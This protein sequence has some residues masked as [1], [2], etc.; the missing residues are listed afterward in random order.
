MTSNKTEKCSNNGTFLFLKKV[1][2][3]ASLLI[4]IAGLGSGWGL[5]ANA[6]VNAKEQREALTQDVDLLEQR[7]LAVEQ[8]VVKFEERTFNIKE[9]L[10]RIENKLQ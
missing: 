6:A 3:I 10:D 2:I 7:I 5:Y 1:A 9:Q 8:A 4:A